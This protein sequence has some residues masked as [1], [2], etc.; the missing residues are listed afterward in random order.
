MKLK[1]TIASILFFSMAYAQHGANQ[2]YENQN[3]YNYKN[4]GVLQQNGPKIIYNEEG[5]TYKINIL[6]NVKPDSFLVTLG[7]NEESLSVKDCN[8]KINKRLDGFKNALKKMGI[9]DE[10]MFV[11]FISQTKIYDY[12]STSTSNQVNISQVDK[13][14]EIKKNI[15][16]K[17]KDA[18]LFDKLID[19]ASEHEIYNVVKVDYKKGDTEKVYDEMLFE[20]NEVLKSRSKIYDKFGKR[21]FEEA[22]QL[23]INFY[24]I[25]PGKQ[26]K[27]YTAFET[28]DTS[29]Y[30]EYYNS[31]KALIRQEQRKSKTFYYDGMDPD[32]FDKVM[33]S[34]SPVVSI[35][36]VMEFSITYKTKKKEEKKNK[37][38]DKKLYHIITPYG[39]VKTLDLKN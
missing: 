7:L 27:N 19:M 39:D 37:E 13:G 15:I 6:N 31:N 9:K 25:Q 2:L 22:P 23:S 8:A 1:I 14:F 26:Y 36:Y 20:A 38:E 3:S 21:D 33:N 30:N 34:E 12:K 17:L 29:Y 18:N 35:Q 28:S 24:S 10:E 4:V 16:I 11:D 5:V 32:S